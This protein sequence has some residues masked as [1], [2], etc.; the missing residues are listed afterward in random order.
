MAAIVRTG[1]DQAGNS[2][3]GYNF[4]PTNDYIPLNVTMK[5]DVQAGQTVAVDTD[6]L[7]ILGDATHG[8]GC[9]TMPTI[10][11]RRVALIMLGKVT[12]LSGMTPSAAVYL[13]ASGELADA[14]TVQVGVA[15]TATDAILHFPLR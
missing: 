11:G 13:G 6:G 1:T 7:G 15:L 3:P 5:V 14:G 4:R 10:A 2:V 9:A 8:L 12:G